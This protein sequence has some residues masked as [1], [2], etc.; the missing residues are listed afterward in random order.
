M[1]QA[2]RSINRRRRKIHRARRSLISARWSVAE[3]IPAQFA[4]DFAESVG[5]PFG[6]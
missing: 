6:P 4:D 3:K 1:R 5:I 2:I